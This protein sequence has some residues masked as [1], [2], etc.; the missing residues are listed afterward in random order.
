MAKETIVSTI[1]KVLEKANQPLSPKEIYQRILK[2]NLYQFKGKNAEGILR[3]QLR[4]H[5]E[6]VNLPA[7]SNVKYFTSLEDGKFWLKNV[8]L[9]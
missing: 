6:N 1:V 3:T 4:R 7:S 2:E 8:K 9:S 5:S